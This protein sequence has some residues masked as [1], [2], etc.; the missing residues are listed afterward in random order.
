MVRELLARLYG[1]D[2]DRVTA[3]IEALLDRHGRRPPSGGVTWDQTDVWL[4]TYA[5]QFQRR[6]EAP[7]STLRA[8]M[9]EQLDWLGVALNAQGLAGERGPPRADP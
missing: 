1:V 3:H 5:D 6:S 9:A 4:I 8:F 2:A 7:L